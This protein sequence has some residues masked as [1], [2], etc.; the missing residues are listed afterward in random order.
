MAILPGEVADR[1]ALKKLRGEP[2]PS[3]TKV[4]VSTQQSVFRLSCIQKRL[5][6]FILQKMNYI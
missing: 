3:L 5:L 6:L 1:K 4:M 2:P